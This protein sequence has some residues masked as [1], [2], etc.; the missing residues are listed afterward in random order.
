MST[1][2][3]MMNPV[4]GLSGPATISIPLP[5]YALKTEVLNFPGRNI[6][7]RVWRSDSSS[8]W[9]LFTNGEDFEEGPGGFI[10]LTSLLL[11]FVAELTDY[12]EIEVF[13]TT[14]DSEDAAFAFSEDDGSF[15]D[16][17]TTSWAWTEITSG[18]ADF[19]VARENALPPNDWHVDSWG[20]ADPTSKAAVLS[21]IPHGS[22]TEVVVLD[23]T[24]LTPSSFNS[25]GKSHLFDRPA[26]GT[27]YVYYGTD[28][29]A[30]GGT[31]IHVSGPFSGSTAD[32]AESARG[33]LFL[34]PEFTVFREGSALLLWYTTA[35]VRT[36]AVDVD[37]GIEITVCQ[38]GSA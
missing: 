29:P 26:G 20:G 17:R 14:L 10:D 9:H 19:S 13:E 8:S 28:D 7:L 12:W 4:C 21:I 34:K 2:S 35:G 24:G 31:A 18:D 16:P 1:F 37:S 3:N 15:N 6:V 23:Y 38:Q 32:L 5:Q 30:S 33:M 25:G 27:Y 11:G 22:N 36:D